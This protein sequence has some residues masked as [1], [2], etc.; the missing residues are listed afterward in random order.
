MLINKSAS[1]CVGW[2]ILWHCL[3]LVSREA[4]QGLITTDECRNLE[5]LS[6]GKSQI[7]PPLHSLHPPPQLFPMLRRAGAM[8]DRLRSLPVPHKLLLTLSS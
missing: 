3:I 6:T 2:V 7:H 8:A 1:H 4:S 5:M